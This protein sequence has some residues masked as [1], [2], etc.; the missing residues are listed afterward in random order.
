MAKI[1]ELLASGVGGILP[2]MMAKEY[3]KNAADEEAAAA[4]AAS[5]GNVGNVGDAGSTPRQQM[6]KGGMTASKRG[7]GIAQRGK[8]RGKMV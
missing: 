3:R 5:V 1:S 2:M 8:T 7:D 4:K 6:K